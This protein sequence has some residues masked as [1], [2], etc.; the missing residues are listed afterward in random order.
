MK[1]SFTEILTGCFKRYF[2]LLMALLFVL[3]SFVPIHLPSWHILKP[4][5]AIIF[6]Y[7]WALYRSDLFGIVSVIILGLAVD[8][9]SGAPFGMNIIVFVFAYILTLRYANYV[10]VKPF[11]ISWVGF[12]F[13]CFISFFLKWILFSVY[14]KTFLSFLH[15][16]IN[17]AE[18]ILIYPLIARLN[19]YVQNEFLGG[20]EILDE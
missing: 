4:D 14:Y 2:P 16:L 11:F 13:V 12:A 8:S 20:D 5:F 3:I 7:F 10:N 6:L 19:M 17:C 1:E 18:T 9:L 15:I